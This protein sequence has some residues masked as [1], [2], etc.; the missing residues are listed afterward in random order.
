MIIGQTVHYVDDYMVKID[1][2]DD[3]NVLYSQPSGI[4]NLAVITYIYDDETVDLIVQRG[5]DTI[6][7]REVKQD[8]KAEHNNTW[9]EV[10]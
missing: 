6:I 7:V 4:H 9:H 2:E 1:E 8:E 3:N 5:L 10:E